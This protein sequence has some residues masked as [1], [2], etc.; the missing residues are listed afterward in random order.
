ML[1]SDD[2][3]NT[4]QK[5]HQ[6]NLKTD[7]PDLKVGDTVKVD[8]MIVEGDKER[9]QAFTGTIIARK[10]V[11]I[12]E[13]VTVRRVERNVGVERVF[14]LHSPRIAKFEVVR[15]GRVCRAKLYYLRGLVGKASRVEES[16]Q[17]QA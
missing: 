2:K 11:G 1:R 15:R 9:V 4:V 13:S 8:V 12:A 14:P 7:L 3:M 16:A 17:Q 5:L 6:E 10:G